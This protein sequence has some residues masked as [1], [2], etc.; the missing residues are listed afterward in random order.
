[1]TGGERG[2]GE[3][4]PQNSIPLT[5]IGIHTVTHNI[6]CQWEGAGSRPYRWEGAGSRPYGGLHKID[7]A[8]TGV[9]SPW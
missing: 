1:M 9:P 6:K 4:V 8:L 7:V 5:N 3:R 2:E